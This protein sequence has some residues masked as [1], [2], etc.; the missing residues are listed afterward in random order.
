LPRFDEWM[1]REASKTLVDLGVDIIL[2]A[3]VDLGSVDKSVVA[4]K[5][6]AETS[7]TVK[8]LDGRVIRA[9][10]IVRLCESVFL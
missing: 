10:L 9:D 2:S 4:N 3:R 7:R 5:G 8:T 6:E 1:H